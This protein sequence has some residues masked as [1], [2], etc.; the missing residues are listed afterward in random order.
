MHGS[1]KE[2][3]KI[4][5]VNKKEREKTE[6]SERK[7]KK[8]STTEKKEYREVEGKH[9]E[10]MK[11]HW[12]SN[13][14]RSS[15]QTTAILLLHSHQ[16]HRKLLQISPPPFFLLLFFF[17]NRVLHCSTWTLESSPLFTRLGQRQPRPKWLGRVQKKTKNILSK[18]SVTFPCI[19]LS[20]F[21]LILVCIFIL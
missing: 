20:K 21:C 18:K 5:I 1:W 2:E 7:K 10:R 15:P 4:K 8:K 9:K 14:H 6:E 12:P 3:L 19:F 13:C 17:L 16:Y 11:N